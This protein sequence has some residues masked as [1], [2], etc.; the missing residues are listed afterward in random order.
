[1]LKG[2]IIFNPV[3]IKFLR[4]E[5]MKSKTITILPL[6]AALGSLAT[7]TLTAT[8]SRAAIAADSQALPNSDTTAGQ[9]V[10]EPNTLVKAGEALLGFTVTDHQDGSVVAQHYSHVSHASHTSHASHYSSR[11]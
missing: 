9:T 10:V 3:E 6:A 4:R 5:H 7:G 1:M 11:Y 2:F 8:D